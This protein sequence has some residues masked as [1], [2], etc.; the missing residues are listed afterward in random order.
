MTDRDEHSDSTD[1]PSSTSFGDQLHPAD[2]GGLGPASRTGGTVSRNRRGLE[3][4]RAVNSSQVAAPVEIVATGP[5]PR[6][7]ELGAEESAVDPNPLERATGASTAEG[8]E[9]T[10][11]SQMLKDL[12]VTADSNTPSRR[13][14]PAEPSAKV[15][16]RRILGALAL[17]LAA[18][19]AFLAFT[20]ISG[21]ASQGAGTGLQA[22]FDRRTA[23]T[24]AARQFS[25]NFFTYDYRTLDRDL[26]RVTDQSTG[27]FYADYVR[28]E[29]N[30]RPLL[31]K[32]KIHA[33]ATVGAA[34]VSIIARDQA[35]VLV[36]IDQSIVNITT[37]NGQRR[38]RLKLTMQETPR[39]WLAV[40]VLPVQ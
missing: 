38:W 34:G 13:A 39:G 17:V 35:I 18:V 21:P 8:A 7:A 4:L 20:L 2:A 27:A 25:V 32:V 30:L 3:R 15:G 24:T 28:Q 37:K 33:T 23:V 31:T 9:P 11:Q 22:Q 6:D 26:K 19:V 40:D 29:P 1:Q 16:T 10:S 14:D 12:P 36:T 5:P